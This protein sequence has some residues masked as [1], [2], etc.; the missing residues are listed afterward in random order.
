[1]R[2]RSLTYVVHRGVLAVSCALL[3]VIV[4]GCDIGRWEIKDDKQGRIIRLDRW[5]GGLAVVDGTRLVA[6][7]DSQAVAAAKTWPEKSLPNLGQRKAYLRTAWRADR[8]YYQ[9]SFTPAPDEEIAKK[10]A[11]LTVSLSDTSGFDVVEIPIALHRMTKIVDAEGKEHSR[12][13]NS[14]VALDYEDY[15]RAHLWDVG[16]KWSAGTK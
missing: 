16:W 4:S 9:F 7:K 12:V 15:L 3:A 1:M 6:I 8:M 13:V 2:D 10:L 14:S 11:E 5:F